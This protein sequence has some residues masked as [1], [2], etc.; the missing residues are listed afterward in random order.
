[1]PIHLKYISV[2]LENL[3]NMTTSLT[4]IND[5]LLI[6]VLKFYI[7][8]LNELHK[9]NTLIKSRNTHITK[10]A[11]RRSVLRLKEKLGGIRAEKLEMRRIKT[12]VQNS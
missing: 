12:F 10:M 2:H 9:H 6:Y 8:F 5:Y 7:I 3:T 1:M 4:I 11:L